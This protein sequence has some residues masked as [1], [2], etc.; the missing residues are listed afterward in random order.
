MK[1]CVDT[2]LNCGESCMKLCVDTGPKCGD[3]CMKLCVDTG[4]KCGLTLH[5]TVCRHRPELSV[6]V[7]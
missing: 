7:T 1:M 6:T 5:E 2:D 4:P 3:S